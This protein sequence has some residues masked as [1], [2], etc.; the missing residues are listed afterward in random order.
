MRRLE[1]TAFTSAT[2][3]LFRSAKRIPSPENCSRRAFAECAC[4]SEV[5]GG[6]FAL[7]E[8]PSAWSISPRN[9]TALWLGSVPVRRIR[10]RPGM[11]DSV[12]A[13][14]MKG[15]SG[16]FDG[17]FSRRQRGCTYR[18]RMSVTFKFAC[19]V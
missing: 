7:T 14:M 9:E 3:G 6:A 4:R 2:L 1:Y 11:C 17:Y 12:F 13:L 10:D 18:I 5:S 19:Q 8:V 15:F 16:L